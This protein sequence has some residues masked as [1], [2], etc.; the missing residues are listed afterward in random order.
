[1]P[2]CRGD[3]RAALSGGGEGGAV[4]SR[5]EVMAS[6]VKIMSEWDLSLFWKG[7]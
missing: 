5:C 1:M 3:R 6:Q 7:D 4:T 2:G